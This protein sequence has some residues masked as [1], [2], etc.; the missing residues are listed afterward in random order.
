M[1]GG[2]APDHLIGSTR[3]HLLLRRQ[4]PFRGY[5]RQAQLL[6]QHHLLPDPA[7]RERRSV[8]GSQGAQGAHRVLPGPEGLR[9]RRSSIVNS[10]VTTAIQ[11]NLDKDIKELPT[12][13]EDAKDFDQDKRDMIVGKVYQKLMEIESRLLPCGLHV[14][15]C[16]PPRRRLSP[17]SP[18]SPASTARMRRFSPAPSSSPA[19]SATTSSA[20]T[21]PTTRASSPRCSSFRTSP[22]RPAR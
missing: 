8:Q 16:P 20:S 4:Q 1:S 7:R 2:A 14:V 9:P 19:P 18:T 12:E 3:T 6:R 21:A 22:R 5:H 17:P 10:I 15:G 13:E 11:C